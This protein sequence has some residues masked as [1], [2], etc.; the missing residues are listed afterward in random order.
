MS[1]IEHMESPRG[2][3]IL[4][5]ATAVGRAQVPGF[6]SVEVHLIVIGDRI[7]RISFQSHGCGYTT[8]CGSMLVELLEGSSLAHAWS[9]SHEQIATALGG[10]PQHKRHCAELVVSA[11]R[12]GLVTSTEHQSD[13]GPAQA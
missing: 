6:G 12:E 10:L 7:E 4:A 5:N 11:L 9:L 1:V 8:A 3:G 2:R 13:I